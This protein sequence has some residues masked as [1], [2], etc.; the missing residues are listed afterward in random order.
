MLSLACRQF[1]E[2]PALGQWVTQQREEARGQKEHQ[3]K[4]PPKK[5]PVTLTR[6]RAAL[7]DQ[8]GFTWKLGTVR[9]T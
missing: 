4:G 7:L 3:V 9:N 5:G 1:W 8:L 2:D 6:Q